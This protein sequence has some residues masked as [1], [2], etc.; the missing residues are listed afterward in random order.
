VAAVCRKSWK[1]I[2]GSSA[3]RTTRLNAAFTGAL[4]RVSEDGAHEE[5]VSIG[6]ILPGGDAVADDGTFCVANFGAFPEI[7]AVVHVVPNEEG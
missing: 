7:G 2:G 4:V 1:R 5:I 6:L 3:S